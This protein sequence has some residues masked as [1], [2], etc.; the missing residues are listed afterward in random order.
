MYKNIK[1]YFHYLLIF[2]FIYSLSA[3]ATE[4]ISLQQYLTQVRQH[5]IGLAG[6][7]LAA[8]GA[9]QRAN[10]GK[11]L[12]EPTFFAEGQHLT[13]SANPNWSTLSGSQNLQSYHL[14]SLRAGISENSPL[15][16][17]SKLY[18]NYQHQKITGA[19]PFL[20]QLKIPPPLRFLKWI[21][22]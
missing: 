22:P 15:G 3:D 19:D 2:F 4:I 5:N 12:T 7:C 1:K 14:Q 18:Y 11:L 21:Y 9:K 8:I 10:E 6:S 17:K 20:A 13:N 16:I